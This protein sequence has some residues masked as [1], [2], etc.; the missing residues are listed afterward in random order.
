MS[1]SITPTLQAAARSAYRQV[2]RSSRT[3][4]NGQQP[5]SAFA[6]TE[7][8][9]QVE[10][11]RL[12]SAFPVCDSGDPHGYATANAKLREAYELDVNRNETDPKKYEERVAVAK[13][14]AE[15]LAKNVVQG[16]KKPTSDAFGQSKAQGSQSSSRT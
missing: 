7:T 9:A 15:F 8:Q 4:F 3:L 1:S 6:N 13:D 5:A 16:E 14:V 11:Y 2:L 10:T 12:V